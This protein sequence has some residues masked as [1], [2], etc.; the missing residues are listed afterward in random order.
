VQDL[1]PGQSQRRDGWTILLTMM[2][3]VVVALVVFGSANGF[4]TSSQAGSQVLQLQ[5]VT[6]KLQHASRS[7][8]SAV[9]SAV[10]EM[11]KEAP[12]SAGGLGL[13]ESSRDSIERLLSRIIDDIAEEVAI[14]QQAIDESHEVREECNTEY[15]GKQENIDDTDL[16]YKENKKLYASKCGDRMEDDEVLNGGF[17]WEKVKSGDGRVAAC[18][19]VPDMFTWPLSKEKNK[20]LHAVLKK[21]RDRDVPQTLGQLSSL[22]SK[23][24]LGDGT[25]S[26]DTLGSD[27]V[28]LHI[29][30]QTSTNEY[31]TKLAQEL[32]DCSL[33]ISSH[34]DFIDECEGFAN[35]DVLG[36]CNLNKAL[37]T[38]CGD[39]SQCSSSAEKNH[40]I[41]LKETKEI[42]RRRAQEAG[43]VDKIHCFLNVL[44]GDYEEGS[45]T[46][47]EDIVKC[48]TRD[49]PDD[50]FGDDGAFLGT[51]AVNVTMLDGYKAPPTLCKADD[52]K[53]DGACKD[54]GEVERAAKKGKRGDLKAIDRDARA[55]MREAQATILKERRDSKKIVISKYATKLE[56]YNAM[57]LENDKTVLYAPFVCR[58]SRDAKAIC[59]DQLS[60]IEAMTT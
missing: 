26:S 32:N 3:L 40:G 21:L 60:H 49:I 17:T 13:N 47:N 24:A 22:L 16:R 38:R 46:K 2:K 12:F 20:D 54:E 33:S 56:A 41:L 23:Q 14:N 48:S 44:F 53:F 29:W 4:Q 36:Y 59:N 51:F 55:A 45:Y 57:H 42:S 30:L 28:L 19:E 43:L 34:E 52:L 39:W 35:T 15:A 8:L 18:R 27:N 11:A 1:K 37:V 6:D 5:R 9:M 50:P 7:D 31:Q 25:A 10:E 58:S